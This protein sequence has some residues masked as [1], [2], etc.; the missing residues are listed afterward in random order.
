[1]MVKLSVLLTKHVMAN[2]SVVAYIVPSQLCVFFFFCIR[3]LDVVAIS[4]IYELQQVLKPFLFPPALLPPRLTGVTNSLH[5][6]F[7]FQKCYL[8]LYL[9]HYWTNVVGT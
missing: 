4:P 9:C 8:S 3:P 5:H 6:Q 2:I 7:G 1:M